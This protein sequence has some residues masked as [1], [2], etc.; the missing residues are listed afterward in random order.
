[1]ARES[2]LPIGISIAAL[3][4]N[5]FNLGMIVG[6]NIEEDAINAPNRLRDIQA[7]NT[8]V[9]EQLKPDYNG[10]GRLVLNDETNTFE[11]R[12]SPEG[13]QAQTCAGEYQVNDAGNASV[14]GQI[15]CTTTTEVSGN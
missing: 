10:L 9:Y 2:M 6:R 3:G 7:H 12:I 13:E 1:M 5:L 14:V 8:Q 4:I 15:A 11:F